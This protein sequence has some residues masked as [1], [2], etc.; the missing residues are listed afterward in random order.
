MEGHKYLAD[1]ITNRAR[2]KA[3]KRLYSLLI[4]RIILVLLILGVGVWVGNIAVKAAHEVPF[5][6]EDV[7]QY[8]NDQM[9]TM[10]YLRSNDRITE[11]VFEYA[12]DSIRKNAQ[13]DMHISRRD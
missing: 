7:R 3:P 10:I 1:Q 13:R 4:I 8:T 5:S 12:C 11:E 9:K 2:R 6:R